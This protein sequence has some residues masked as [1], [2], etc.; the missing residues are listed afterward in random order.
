MYLYGS[1]S[2]HQ[3]FLI[4]HLLVEKANDITIGLPHRTRMSPK[5]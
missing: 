5:C 4:N 1:V 2:E 3:H